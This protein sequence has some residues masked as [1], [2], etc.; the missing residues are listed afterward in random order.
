MHLW[1]CQ[2]DKT[3]KLPQEWFA[4][5]SRNNTGASGWKRR[6][7]EQH[8]RVS[9]HQVQFLLLLSWAILS[10]WRRYLNCLG[11]FAACDALQ[12]YHFNFILDS[13]RLSHYFSKYR[14][15][16]KSSRNRL[17]SNY[18]PNLHGKRSTHKLHVLIQYKS[19]PVL[20]TVSPCLAKP[21]ADPN[22]YPNPT[23]HLVP[24][25]FG[26]FPAQPSVNGNDSI[27]HGFP[28]FRRK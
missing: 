23:Q 15:S 19:S 25:N 13:G 18:F 20:T 27:L 4:I 9:K 24:S 11:L 12:L 10:G 22:S 14:E 26:K 16:N 21:I 3:G 28:F 5:S 6:K 8:R 17:Y 7:R 1:K 2:F